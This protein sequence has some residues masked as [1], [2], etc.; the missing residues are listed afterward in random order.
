MAEA[1]TLSNIFSA[2]QKMFVVLGSRGGPFGEVF[3]ENTVNE[4]M[5]GYADLSLYLLH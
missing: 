1:T 5:I 3:S 2:R 4:D